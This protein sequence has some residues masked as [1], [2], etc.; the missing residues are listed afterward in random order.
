MDLKCAMNQVST[1]VGE[2]VNK[3]GNLNGMEVFLVRMGISLK[4]F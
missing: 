4:N 1:N 3:D 2:Y